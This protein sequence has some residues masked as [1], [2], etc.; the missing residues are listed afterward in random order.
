MEF[1]YRLNILEAAMKE[2][3]MKMQEIQN[4]LVKLV[5]TKDDQDKNP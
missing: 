3:T 4:E 5:S 1:K 2:L